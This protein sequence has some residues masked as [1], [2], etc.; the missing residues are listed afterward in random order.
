VLRPGSA[1]WIYPQGRRRP[2]AESPLRLERGA[3]HL[4]VRH[5]GL[6]RICPVAF[7]YPFTSEQLPEALALVGG[8]WLHD[9]GDDRRVL[10][11]RIGAAMHETLE[12]LDAR[13]A[14]EALDGFRTLVPGQLSLNKRMDRVRHSLGLLRGPFQ[15]RNG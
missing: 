11:E 9:G 12:G 1:L 13:I 3:A 8:S 7:R 15:A 10:T 5:D 2:A 6:L 14:V 4:A